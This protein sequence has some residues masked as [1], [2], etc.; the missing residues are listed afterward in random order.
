MSLIKCQVVNLKNNALKRDWWSV[1]LHMFWQIQEVFA[2]SESCWETQILHFCYRK[3]ISQLTMTSEKDWAQ[4]VS[5]VD[6]CDEPVMISK[7]KFFIGRS[8]GTLTKLKNLK[9]CQ[10]YKRSKHTTV[11]HVCGAPH[12]HWHWHWHC[13]WHCT[14]SV[15]FCHLTN[16]DQSHFF[17]LLIHY[18]LTAL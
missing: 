12:C 2:F 13:H 11:W 7:D 9:S 4:L 10:T 14:Q 6:I 16:I 15:T 17:N 1:R 3:R 18:L 8:K 5:T